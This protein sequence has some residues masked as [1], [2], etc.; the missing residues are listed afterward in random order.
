MN[1]E[2]GT[3]LYCVNRE[4]VLYCVNREGVLYCVNGEGILCEQGGGIV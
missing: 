3:V 4:G 2:G 1:R